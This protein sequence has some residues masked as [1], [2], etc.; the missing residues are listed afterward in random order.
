MET[1]HLAPCFSLVSR[2]IQGSPGW[3]GL[4]ENGRK[5]V[6]QAVRGKAVHFSE[7]EHLPGYSFFKTNNGKTK[8]LF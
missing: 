5:Q 4:M 6:L 7:V 2:S 1:D 8:I 3:H